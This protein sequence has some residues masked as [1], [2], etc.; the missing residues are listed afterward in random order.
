MTIRKIVNINEEKCNGCGL[1]I[2]K[3]AEGALQIINGKAK[4]ISDEFCDGLGACLGHCSQNAITVIERQA[5]D[6]N[7]EAVKKN[8][9]LKT[10]NIHS[11]NQEQSGCSCP[12]TTTINLRD[13]STHQETDKLGTTQSELRQWPIQIKL[14]PPNAPYLENADLLIAADCVPFS[15]A[16]F[17]MEFLKDKVL[18]IGCPKLDDSQ[19]YTEKLTDILRLN[20]IKSV[21]LVNMEV[22]C[23]FGLQ[24]ITEEAIRKSGKIIPLRQTIVTIKGEKQ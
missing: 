10:K 18:T 4:L 24:N 17:H 5:D 7:E 13:K 12:G 19:Y 11:L 6:F 20:N 2:P 8:L 1:C 9:N 22:P 23:C 16:N 14:I 3:C 21:T 15:Y